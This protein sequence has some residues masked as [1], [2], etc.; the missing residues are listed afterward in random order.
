[1]RGKILAAILGLF[2]LVAFAQFAIAEMPK[3]GTGSATTF[4]S[5]TFTAVPADKDHYAVH[6][7]NKGVMVSDDKNSPFNN[8]SVY[9]VGTMYFQNGVGRLL[10]YMT[11]T[12]PEGDKVVIELME[13]NSKPAPAPGGNTGTGKFIYGTGKFAGIEG[14][15]EYKRWYVYPATK[16]S[17]QAIGKSK[18]SWKIP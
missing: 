11:C 15:T 7:S 13:T 4:Y 16:D 2:I 5:G 3:E 9:H 14:T 10:G 17:Y 1:M 18:A 6:Y 8:M 12:D